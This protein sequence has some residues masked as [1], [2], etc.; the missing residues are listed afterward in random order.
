MRGYAHPGLEPLA[1]EISTGRAPA[2]GNR[3]GAVDLEP[4]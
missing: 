2:T 4:A 3:K 1:R